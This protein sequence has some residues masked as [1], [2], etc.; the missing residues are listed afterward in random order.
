[1]MQCTTYTE[2]GTMTGLYTVT[3]NCFIKETSSSSSSSSGTGG[4]ETTS[5]EDIA[6]QAANNAITD[7][8][9]GKYCEYRNDVDPVDPAEQPYDGT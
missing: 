5:A 3:E 6:T 7:T 4:T 2:S 1:M 9:T 8:C